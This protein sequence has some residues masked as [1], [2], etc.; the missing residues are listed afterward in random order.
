MS[1]LH[2]SGPVAVPRLMPPAAPPDPDRQ[3]GKGVTAIPAAKPAVLRVAAYCRVSTDL[4]EQEGSLDA[5]T[6]H[7]TDYISRHPGWSLAGIYAE[8]GVSAT[9]AETRPALME[10]L[11]HCREGK[12]HLIL[13]KSIS[14]FSRNTTDCLHLVRTLKSLGVGIL[15]E[16]E[17]IDTGSMTSEL[18]LTLLASF[19]AEESRSISRNVKMGYTH[20]FQ[21][22]TYRY[23]R[24]PYGYTVEDGN[25][26][27]DAE[28]SVVV[29]EIFDMALNGYGP[30]A[31]A[32]HLI[33]NGV[34]TKYNATWTG[35]TVSMIIS[36]LTYTGDSLLQKTYKDERYCKRMNSGELNQYYIPEHHEAIVNREVFILAN[37]TLGFGDPYARIKMATEEQAE[38]E[39]ERGVVVIKAKPKAALKGKAGRLRVAAY[40]RVSTDLAEQE[41]SFEAQCSHYSALIT[42]NPNWMLAGI[43]ADE[44]ISGTT[45]FHRDGFNRMIEDAEAGK[46]DLVLTKSISRFA[47][48]TLDCLTVVR[49]LK[50]IG[51]GI[52]FE[53][54]GLDTLDGTGEVILTILASIAQQESMSISQNVRL[55]I[56]YRF[57]Q[58]K[59]LVNCSRFLGYDKDRKGRLIINEAQAGVVRRIYRDFLDGYSM[60]M[61]C[62][63][64]RREGVGSASGCAKWPESSVRYIL[65]N[66]KYA[67]DLL[68]QKTLVEDFLTH[69]VVKNK[70]QLPQYYV[71]GAHAPIV[72]KCIFD[73]AAD[74]RFLRGSTKKAGGN[75]FG[76]RMALKGRTWCPCGGGMKRLR[77]AEPVFKCNQCGMEIA[78]AA[79]KRQVMEAVRTLP[80]QRAEIEARLDALNDA[81]HSR[82]RQERAVAQRMEWRLHNLLPEG[83][84]LLFTAACY[85]EQDFRARTGKRLTEW[86]DSALNRV[87]A[88]VVAGTETAFHGGIVVR[89]ERQSLLP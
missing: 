78:E 53:K 75:H 14:R 19:A 13:T 18:F 4:T 7:Y 11:T 51:V 47:R 65:G 62:Y 36:N 25:L 23:T 83:G 22:G 17:N 33:S 12:I 72:P 87:L 43:Y 67:G 88:S 35:H 1:M 68:L 42:G 5:Q 9:R 41:G 56:Q 46:I 30:T 76:S 85:D 3:A 31:I 71:E 50:S 74:E 57:Q 37:E 89:T 29:Q 69:K 28:E 48:N 21:T 20:R 70:G 27:V 66:E 6:A 86:D 52:T 55:G 82:S 39:E 40:C 59:P 60:D 58:G 63:D 45:R 2:L 49:R 16:K 8:Q 26:A 38:Q 79:L 84:T 54:E 32:N 44:G 61:I 15:F 10:L 73:R 64:L 81:L 80:D 34:P 24:P 77:R